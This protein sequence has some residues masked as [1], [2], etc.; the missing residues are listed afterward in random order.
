MEE[1]GEYTQAVKIADWCVQRYNHADES[2]DDQNTVPHFQ[3][4]ANR[5][6]A[7]IPQE[8]S[9]KEAKLREQAD[10]EFDEA[11]GGEDIQRMSDLFEEAFTTF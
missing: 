4:L 9:N 6:R 10:A 5:C 2:Q 7:K 8:R 11:F 1:T 3:E